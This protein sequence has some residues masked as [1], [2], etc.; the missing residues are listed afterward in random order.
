MPRPF[1]LDPQIGLPYVNAQ[2]GGY[3]V[4]HDSVIFETP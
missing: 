2:D 1:T 4:E 3:V